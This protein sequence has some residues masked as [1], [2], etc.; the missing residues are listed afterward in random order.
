MPRLNASLL[1]ALI[2]LCRVAGAE[3]Y[4]AV[5]K[6]MQCSSCHSHPA[7][8][9]KRVVYGNVFAQTELAER[10]LGDPS[11]KLWTG[12]VTS[13]LSVGANVR[14]GYDAVDVPGF[15]ADS[16]VDLTRATVYLEASLI[17]NRLSLYLDEKVA[18]DDVDERELYLKLKT[19]DSRF[20]IAAGQ[21]FLPY[22]LRLQD[23][24]AF[25]R[26]ATGVNFFQPDRGVQLGFESGPWSTQ[27]SLTNGTGS[28]PLL[29]STD[30]LSFVA[31]YVKQRWRAGASFSATDS[32]VGDRKMQNVF[33]GL[34]TGPVAW[35][36]ELDF[37]SD[38]VPGSGSV[39]ALAG[40]IEG[41]WMYRQ[42]HNLKVSY[43]YLDPDDDISEVHQVRWSVLWEYSPIQFL[44][45][46]F[47]A[48]F[49]DGIPQVPFQDRDEYFIELHAFF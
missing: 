24:S 13:W 31:Q 43:E 46:R 48:R 35:L 18:P 21:F 22:G 41:N 30:R 37:I 40:L 25:V 34:R 5:F 23:D 10:R 29:E 27:A 2:A 44:Q 17:P 9:G 7:G 49:Y 38:D 11:A 42:G 32:P 12:E 1:I 47:G 36:G 39:D 33:F 26:R 14:G 15:G 4:L 3:P 6:G 28:G 19:R 8:A 45:A 16:D 20:F